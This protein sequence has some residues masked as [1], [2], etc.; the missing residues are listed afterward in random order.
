MRYS[1]MKRA[2][3][4]AVAATLTWSPALRAGDLNAEIG[5]MM[6]NLGGTGNYTEPGAFRGQSMNTFSAG[7]LMYRAPIR[8]YRLKPFVDWPT[9][10]GSC[11]GIDIFGGSFSVISA[12]KLKQMLQQ[13]TSALPGLAFQLAVEAVS[14]AF[15]SKIQW[16]KDLEQG[17]T[18]ESK[19]SCAMAT[20]L[21]RGAAKAMN[22]DSE[23]GCRS[24]ARMMNSAEDAAAA[25]ARCEGANKVSILND[26]RS[27][28]NPE[29]K[30]ELPVTGN[31]VWLALKEVDD[32]TLSDE[33]RELIM[34]MFGTIIYDPKADGAR[35][36]VAPTI[37][38]I[39]QLLY[40]DGETAGTATATTKVRVL[41]C[42]D[43]HVQ[44]NEVSEVDYD[45][46]PFVMR[47]RDNLNAIVDRVA[48]RTDWKGETDLVRFV[49]AVGTPV[50]RMVAVSTLTSDLSPARALIQKY[51]LLIAADYA[52]AFLDRYLWAG[53]NAAAANN[54]LSQ[55]QL[56]EI[57]NLQL[58]ARTLIGRLA[59]TKI[60]INTKVSSISSM[61]E[62]LETLGRTLRSTGPVQTM[63]MISGA[64]T[65]R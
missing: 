45:L 27:S 44:C 21:V 43:N 50:Y 3:A 51:E 48:T 58:N 53:V 13:I 41:R 18:L 22:Y 38:R 5:N 60:E 56:E 35:R 42:T 64:P 57:R 7:S 32:A 52:S 46:T 62:E 24:I 25:E 30:K 8:T 65:A 20:S 6:N 36:E 55:P 54:S 49:N 63:N 40:G 33:E 9:A 4:L 19:N 28:T 17:I 11:A 31:L 29:V 15:A 59:A 23:Q 37:R 26:G 61:Q 16:L 34:S 12:D 47:V 1:R 14:P 39:E 2:V 10:R